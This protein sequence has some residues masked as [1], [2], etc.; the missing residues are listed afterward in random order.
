MTWSSSF[1]AQCGPKLVIY[2]NIDV[3]SV[4]ILENIETWRKRAC[5]R[6]Y[7]IASGLRRPAS[8]GRVR[9][10]YLACLLIVIR[11]VHATLGGKGDE[12]IAGTGPGARKMTARNGK[13]LA[14]VKRAESDTGRTA[15]TPLQEE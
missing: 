13:P 14:K 4:H 7:F 6:S 11:R 5:A 15:G 12:R 8:H 3:F 9:Q 10:T 1:A 2:A